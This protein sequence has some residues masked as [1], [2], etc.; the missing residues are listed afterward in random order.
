VLR[1]AVLVGLG[2]LHTMRH[3]RHVCIQVGV[4]LVEHAGILT[5]IKLAGEILTGDQRRRKVGARQQV[6]VAGLGVG[7]RRA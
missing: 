1:R 4:D 6:G 5:E 2:A 3:S 7:R